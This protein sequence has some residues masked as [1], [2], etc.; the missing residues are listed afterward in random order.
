MHRHGYKGRK[1]GRER[2]QRRALIKGL[3]SSLIEHGSITTTKAKAKEIRPYTEKLITKAKK[4]GLANQRSVMSSLSS[5]KAVNRLINE[6]VPSTQNRNSGY[7]RISDAGLR[8]GDGAEMAKISFVDSIEVPKV[9]GKKTLKKSE[10]KSPA[11]KTVKKPA[12]SEKKK[13]KVK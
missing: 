11:K 4:G 7:L 6:V 3:A 9:E 13:E 12:K 10:Q 8:R 1:F 2:D 5:P